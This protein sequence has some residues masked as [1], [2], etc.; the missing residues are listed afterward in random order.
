VLKKAQAFRIV[1]SD[2][3]FASLPR[4]IVKQYL[5]QQ[6]KIVTDARHDFIRRFYLVWLFGVNR[7]LNYRFARE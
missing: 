5:R 4:R 1:M 2:L 7:V 3:S 6:R